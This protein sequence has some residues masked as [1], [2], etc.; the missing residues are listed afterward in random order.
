MRRA[1][2]A[3]LCGKGWTLVLAG[4]LAAGMGILCLLHR[5]LEAQRPVFEKAASRVWL[6]IGAPVEWDG[7]EVSIDGHVVGQLKHKLLSPHGAELVL[8]V[9]CGVH[10]LNFSQPGVK[11][12]TVRLRLKGKENYVFVDESGHLQGYPIIGPWE[13][14]RS[15]P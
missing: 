14:D 9:P 7:V 3:I 5:P 2:L 11:G 1:R 13:R 6:E 8:R 10:T 4:L 12:Y 15:E